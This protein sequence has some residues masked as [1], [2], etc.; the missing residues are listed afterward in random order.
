MRKPLFDHFRPPI[1]ASKINK[2][3][4][5]QPASWNSFLS[6]FQFFQKAIDLG[7]R[8]KL[9]VPM[10]EKNLLNLAR[11][12]YATGNVQRTRHILKKVLEKNSNNIKAKE[13][14]DKLNKE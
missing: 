7:E 12:Y 3:S 2:Y 6:F 5:Y 4:S 10:H 8:M 9:R 1:L 13:F 11:S 14:F